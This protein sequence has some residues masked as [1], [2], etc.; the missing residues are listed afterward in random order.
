MPDEEPKFGKLEELPMREHWKDEARD[1]TPW[2]KENIN[3]LG[4]ALDLSL[5]AKQTEAPIG[6]FSLDL[7]A[8]EEDTGRTAAIENQFHKTDHS[9]LG[10][11]LTYAAGCDADIVIWVVEKARDEHRAAVEWL[12]R[13]TDVNTNFYLVKVRVLRIDDS[14]PAY[15]FVPVVAPNTFQKEQRR[16][17]VELTPE[18]E[19]SGV[20]FDKF[21]REMEAAGFPYR[22]R[23]HHRRM[24]WRLYYSG[25]RKWVYGH[26]WSD[27]Y[28]YV[29]FI[30]RR[31]NKTVAA[32]L[33]KQLENR[34]AEIDGKLKM[35]WG[36]EEWGNDIRYVG[37][38]REGSLSD[39]E[40]T[41]AEIRAWAVESMLKLAEAIPPEMLEEI[42]AT[43]EDESDSE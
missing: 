33:R 40:E 36:I 11:L 26:E 39:S 32:K 19:M 8:E 9:H 5:S 16:Q 2:L 31:E 10:Q 28:A 15:E 3:A 22:P 21:A 38:F 20:Y 13:K 23:K 7:L 43:A 37:V 41:L 30:F 6:D 14:K 29:E 42:A 12:N 25:V 35:E 17:A 1:F 18:E 24:P 34:K 4:D 27:G